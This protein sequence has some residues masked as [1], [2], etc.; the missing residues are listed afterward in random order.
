MPDTLVSVVDHYAVRHYVHVADEF[1]ALD[2]TTDSVGYLGLCTSHIVQVQSLTSDL[3]LV[4]QH[5]EETS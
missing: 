4:R 3:D 2:P 1:K 5:R